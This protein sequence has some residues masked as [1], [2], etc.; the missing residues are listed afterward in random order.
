MIGGH[1]GSLHHM[2]SAAGEQP[3]AAASHRAREVVGWYG[4]PDASW[5]IGVEVGLTAPTDVASLAANWVDL[6]H[7][8]PDLGLPGEVHVSDVDFDAARDGAIT[9]DYAE[10]A[11]LVRVVLDESGTR[12]CVAAHHGVV[13]GLGLLGI[14]QG[15]TRQPIT[16][17]ARGIGARRAPH[18]FLVSGVRR[19][20]EALLSPPGR[21]AGTGEPDSP[22]E[23]VRKA[24][25]APRR[26]GTADLAAAVLSAYRELGTGGQPVVLVGASRRATDRLAPDRQTAYL[27]L[28]PG[29]SG[30]DRTRLA[31]LLRAVPPEPAFPESSSGGIGP[32]IVGLL[33]RRLGG[34][35]LLS[36]LGVIAGSGVSEVSMYPAPSGPRAVVWGLAST[37]EATTLTLR[38]RRRDFT[39][40]E[41]HAIWSAVLA[42][43]GEPGAA[44]GGCGQ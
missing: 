5:S 23:D 39:R 4:D 6:C 9:S 20:A 37:A 12:L 1:D 22:V 34:T 44:A 41:S 17:A 25:F 26:W 29:R 30:A 8:A 11:P 10:G 7:Q 13:D 40:A 35:T 38:T 3:A 16:S 18:G 31:A 36:N 21:F 32:L 27:R 2:V 15:L 14:V 42:G 43:L 24:V 19:V 33:R 28:R